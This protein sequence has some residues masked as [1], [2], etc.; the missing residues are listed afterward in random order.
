MLCAW[1]EGE[2]LATASTAP[3][4]QHHERDKMYLSLCVYLGSNYGTAVE[5]QSE[6]AEMGSW[7]LS[8][9]V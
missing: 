8:D 7:V 3:F 5:S 2:V 6:A 9:L 4:I 1:E